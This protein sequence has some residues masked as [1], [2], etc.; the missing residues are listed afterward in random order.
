M[1]DL[2]ATQAS[3]PDAH[4]LFV[5]RRIDFSQDLSGFLAGEPLR[6]RLALGQVLLAHLGARNGSDFRPR[7]N[8]AFFLVALFIYKVHQLFKRHRNDTRLVRILLQH[9]LGLIRI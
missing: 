8:L 2:P 6:Q 4:A 3:E 9:L 7:R 5:A 1:V